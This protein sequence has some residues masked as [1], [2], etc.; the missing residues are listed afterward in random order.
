EMIVVVDRSPVTKNWSFAGKKE[1]QGD[2][3]VRAIGLESLESIAFHL[4]IT[5]TASVEEDD[6][7]VYL[8]TF[9]GH[10]FDDNGNLIPYTPGQMTLAGH[11]AAKPPAQGAP[12]VAADDPTLGHVLDTNVRGWIQQKLSHELGI[13]PRED[14]DEKLGEA[15]DNCFNEAK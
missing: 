15:I 4:G 7:H 13:V 11:V 9:G 2:K 5:I 3:P 10:V 8:Y 6:A 14:L 1:E 12:A